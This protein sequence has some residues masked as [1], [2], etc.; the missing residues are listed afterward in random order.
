MCFVLGIMDMYCFQYGLLG[1]TY[2][3]HSVLLA[4]D[5]QGDESTWLPKQIRQRKSDFTKAIVKVR[6]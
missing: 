3:T 6:A 4:D 2:T 5:G 1:P